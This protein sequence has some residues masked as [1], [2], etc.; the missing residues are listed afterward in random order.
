MFWK[1]KVGYGTDPHISHLEQAIITRAMRHAWCV[2][3]MLLETKA[4]IH[5]EKETIFGAQN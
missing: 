4:Q 5:G 2:I 3:Y 1:T